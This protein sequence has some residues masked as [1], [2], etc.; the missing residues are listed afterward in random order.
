MV[1]QGEQERERRRE[2]A[3]AGQEPDQPARTNVRGHP[4]PPPIRAPPWA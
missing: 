3:G 2:P 1:T 4:P